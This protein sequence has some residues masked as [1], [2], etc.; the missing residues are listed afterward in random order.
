MKG[1]G[2]N[3]ERRPGMREKEGNEADISPSEDETSTWDRRLTSRVGELTDK[4][5][6]HAGTG[7]GRI[8]EVT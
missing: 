3:Q 2:E 1:T 8:D 5:G 6:V 7:N 4:L